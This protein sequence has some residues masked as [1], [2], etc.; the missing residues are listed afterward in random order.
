M[1][2]RAGLGVAAEGSASDPSAAVTDSVSAGELVESDGGV[3]VVVEDIR[4]GC[5]SAFR[6]DLLSRVL[7]ASFRTTA[8]S[9]ASLR[10]RGIVMPV[11]LAE[12]NWGG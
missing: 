4:I 12:Y 5:P 1:A 8:A 6:Y 9:L 10:V 7:V 11:N 3:G 2:W